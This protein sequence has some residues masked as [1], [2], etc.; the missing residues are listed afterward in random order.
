MQGLGAQGRGLEFILRGLGSRQCRDQVYIGKEYSC[1]LYGRWIVE[2]QESAGET[3]RRL[4]KVSA[5]AEENRREE[6][7]FETENSESF[8]RQRWLRRV[9]TKSG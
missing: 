1:L 5:Q 3:I 4:L 8:Q 2:G 7:E 9:S 6:D